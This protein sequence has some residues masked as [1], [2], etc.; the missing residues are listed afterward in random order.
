MLDGMS[1]LRDRAR[2]PGL[3]FRKAMDI[4]QK[5]KSEDGRT[6]RCAPA[7]LGALKMGQ[8][9]DHQVWVMDKPCM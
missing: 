1:E 4:L 6:R 5:D 2:I 9:Q 7:V 8:S 3:L